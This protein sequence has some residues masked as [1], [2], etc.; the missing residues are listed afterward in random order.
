MLKDDRLIDLLEAPEIRQYAKAQRRNLGWVD[1][2]RVDPLSLE[3]VTEIWT[4]RGRTT[5]RLEFVK[6]DEVKS[7]PGRTTYDGSTLV[8]QIPERIH[9]KAFMGDGYARFVVAREFGHATLRHPEMLTALAAK[10]RRQAEG[11]DARK[12]LVSGFQ[13]A[14]FQAG[15]FAAALLIHDDTARE[16]ASLEEI[17]VRAGIDTLSARVYFEQIVGLVPVA[18]PPP[19]SKK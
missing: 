19:S 2:D 12:V 15:V 14:Q 17:S 6:D 18:P 1:A 7:D 8:V 10:F 4:V 16:L 3:A 11:K 9:R 5:F 13:S